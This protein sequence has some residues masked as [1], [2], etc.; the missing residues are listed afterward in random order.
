MSDPMPDSPLPSTGFSPLLPA[1]LASREPDDALTASTRL[2][3]RRLPSGRRPLRLCEQFPRVANRLAF[4]WVDPAIREQT[5]EDLLE[6]R[7]GGRQGF[8]ASVVRELQRLREF[9][10]LR[11]D[12][13]GGPPWW[14]AMVKAVRN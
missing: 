6:D 7:R 2:W 3:L 4:C 1:R 10:G 5:L 12:E 13:T 9:G 11:L 8:P 14:R